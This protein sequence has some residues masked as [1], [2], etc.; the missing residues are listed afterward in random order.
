MTKLALFKSFSEIER[1]FQTLEGQI[2]SS[3]EST[4]E[5][6]DAAIKDEQIRKVF[7]RHKKR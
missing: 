3:A 1:Q 2:R 6:L 5:V 7:S 4:S